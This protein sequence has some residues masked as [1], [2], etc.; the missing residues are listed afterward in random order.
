[1][2][3]EI[4]FVVP[5]ERAGVVLLEF[6]ATRFT[7]HTREGW[8]ERMAEGRVTVNAR[9]VAP[10]QTLL[11]GD[12]LA[13]EASD[14]PEPPMDDRIDLVH[15]DDVL[16]VVNKSGNLTCHPGGRYFNHTLWA[17]LKKRHG[18]DD[19]TFV[20]RIDRETSGLVVVARAPAAA[21]NLRAQFSG[22]AVE[23]RYVAL[24]EGAF[25]P[26][27]SAA[28]WVAVDFSGE[29]LKKR[30]FV[31]V[32]V[33]ER[34]PGAAIHPPADCPPVTPDAQW[35]ATEFR[36]LAAHGP[37]SEIEARPLTGRLH[38]IR[39]T[40]QT[41]G[42]PVVGDKMYGLDPSVFL[43]F[44]RDACTPEDRI[45]M[46][47]QRQALHAAGLRFRHPRFGRSLAFALPLPED[48]RRAIADCG[49]S[50]S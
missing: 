34:V 31:P 39:V 49:L 19:P 46:R 18:V 37:V 44:C 6:L 2:R 8:I 3:R 24:V 45:R 17:L 38:Q 16:A 40:L 48:M 14:I 25:P 21:L 12:V 9:P 47:M 20:N 5:P 1:M 32:Q 30:R 28:G 23:K 42:F 26:A 29:L 41:L 27:L 4:R 7:Y 11:A 10:E 15:L 13:Y 36:L 43:R 50:G 22:R 33:S 35:A